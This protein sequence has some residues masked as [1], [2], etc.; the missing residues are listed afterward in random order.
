MFGVDDKWKGGFTQASY[1]KE[2][3]LGKE[4]TGLFLGE[5]TVDLGGLIGYAG[6][7]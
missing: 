3:A 4:K 1:F 6:R 5:Q 7:G 2:I